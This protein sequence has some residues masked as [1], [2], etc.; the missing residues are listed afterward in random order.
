MSDLFKKTSDVDAQVFSF[1]I[2]KLAA[3]FTIIYHFINENIYNFYK[4]TYFNR[5]IY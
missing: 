1:T 4:N 5:S 3:N 2:R